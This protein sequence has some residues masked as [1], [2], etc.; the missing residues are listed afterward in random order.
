MLR[1]AFSFMPNL[2]VGGLYFHLHFRA[3][4]QGGGMEIGQHFTQPLA[5]TFG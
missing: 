1:R 2:H 3:D 4:W 5:F